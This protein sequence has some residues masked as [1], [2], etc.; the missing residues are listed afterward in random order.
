MCLCWFG[1]FCNQGDKLW[2]SD[3]KEI[4]EIAKNDLNKI[5]IIDTSKISDYKVVRQEKAYPVY[6]ENYKS[7][8][9]KIVQ[10][11][12]TNYKKTMYMVGRNGMHKYNN[13]DH[14]MM[15][16]IPTVIIYLCS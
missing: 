4:L 1:V 13:Q 15:S 10:E 5:S 16:S 9:A 2:S 8:V 11:L 12:K 7:S 6:D 3:D 14:A